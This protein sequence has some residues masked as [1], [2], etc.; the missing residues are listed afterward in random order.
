MM[1]E[2]IRQHEGVIDKFIG[3]AIMAFWGPPFVGADQHAAKACLAAIDFVKTL[4]VFRSEMP[5]LMGIKRGLPEIDIQI[6]I[7]SGDVVIGNIGADTSRSY[8]VMGVTVNL[9]SRLESVNKVYGT[10][11]LVSEETAKRAADSIATREIDSIAVAGKND[12]V[13]I[14]E[15]LGK[16]GGLDDEVLRLRHRFEEGL[17]AYRRRD[18]IAAAA[19]FS[20]CAAIAPNDGPSKV[21]FDRVNRLRAD[22]PS[23]DW[24]GVWRLSEK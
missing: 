16:N 22:P 17:A 6:G 21:F 19:A 9:A 23:P 18:W 15:I 3:D 2:P 5:E 20:D 7:A 11:L 8:T 10:R 13:R 4:A 12:A 14:F 24:D 1:S